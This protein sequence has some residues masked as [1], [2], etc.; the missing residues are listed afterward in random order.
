M[1]GGDRMEVIACT[2]E[3]VIMKP[4]KNC[5]KKKGGEVGEEGRGETRKS[6]RSNQ[7]TLYANMEISQ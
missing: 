5:K 2:Y 1:G 7:N 6:N 3:N 4:I